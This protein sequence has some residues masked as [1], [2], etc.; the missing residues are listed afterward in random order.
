MNADFS[1]EFIT[2]FAGL[3]KIAPA[4]RELLRGSAANGPMLSPAWMLS[5][6]RVFGR[7]NGRRLAAAA[8]RDGERLVGLAPLTARRHW[9]RPGIP[10]RRLEPLGTGEAEADAVCPDYLCPIAAPGAEAAVATR[11][12]GLL[13]AG[14]LGPWDE[15]VWPR[16]DGDSALTTL[17]ADA[18]ARAGLE[19]AIDSAG[20]SPYIPLPSTWDAYLRSLSS[21]H[22]Y[23]INR[24]LRDF[25]RWAGDSWELRTAASLEE[26]KE[27]MHILIALHGQRWQAAGQAGAF[28]SPLFQAF[29][30]ALAPLL[31]EEGALEL[32]WLCVRGVPVAALYNIVWD[33]KVYFYQGGRKMDVPGAVRP[34]I[35][36]HAHAIRR[37][38]AAGRRE[39]D[40]LAVPARYKT[41]LALRSRPLVDL[42]VARPSLRELARRLAARGIARTRAW[43][44]ARGRG[45]EAE[46]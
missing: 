9:H 27:G 20:E 23:Y 43:F 21:T 42:R 46:D 25:D 26:L 13:A 28:A 12:A 4:W 30:Q 11:L 14:A 24:S 8:F 45:A 39:Y 33:G 16:L 37:A 1:T 32:L 6:W 44:G 29:H 5:W 2:D 38:I 19:V 3:E 7:R 18:L 40:F 41:K 31:L 36:L 22:R 34:G 17:L 10:F 35:V 15:M